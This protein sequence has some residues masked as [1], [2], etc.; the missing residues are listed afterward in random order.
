MYILAIVRGSPEGKRLEHPFYCFFG[1]NSY[2][3][4]LTHLTVLGLMHG[5]L[6]NSTPDISTATQ[7]AVT[8]AAL[9][10]SAFIGWL[11]TQ[12]VEHPITN[13]GRT[14]KWSRELR[15]PKVSASSTPAAGLELAS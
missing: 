8:F 15:A 2:S 14:W 3:I 6:L 4:Y 13:Y 9:P 10:V 11:F 1:T 7:L 12:I 5:L